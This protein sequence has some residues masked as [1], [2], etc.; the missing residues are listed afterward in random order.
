VLKNAATL[1][2]ITPDF[3]ALSALKRPP[4]S[5]ALPARNLISSPVFFAPGFGVR[6]D[7]VTGSAHCAPISD[8][9]HH[10]QKNPLPPPGNA[11]AAAAAFRANNAAK[12][13]QS[14][15]TPRAISRAES[16]QRD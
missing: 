12:A 11:R 5:S 10:S 14:P 4:S 3:A 9:T 13:F 8:G 15:V 16:C 2:K 1:A 7:P 6:E